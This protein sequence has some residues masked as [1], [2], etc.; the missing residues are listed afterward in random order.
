MNENK[1]NRN[2]LVKFLLGVLG[3]LIVAAIL[4]LVGWQSSMSEKVSG[5]GERLAR[6]ESMYGSVKRIETFILERK[7]KDD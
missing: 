5:H 1:N 3:S 6:L 7:W 2:I 4:G